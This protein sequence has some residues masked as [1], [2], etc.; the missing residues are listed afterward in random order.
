MKTPDIVALDIACGQKS[1]TS[2]FA[3]WTLSDWTVFEEMRTEQ[4][5]DKDGGCFDPTLVGD[6]VLNHA[7]A[8]RKKR[9]HEETQQ[10]MQ[11]DHAYRKRMADAEWSATI[12]DR[13]E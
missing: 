1:D 12:V 4:L 7:I 5:T 11:E 6:P 2:V 3:D 13:K 10:M 8:H 9:E